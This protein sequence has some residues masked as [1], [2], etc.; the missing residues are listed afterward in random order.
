M[1]TVGF[2]DITPKNSY[3]IS[4]TIV[5]IYCA[6]G[7]FAYTINSI[8]LILQQI[9]NKERELKRN[10]NTLNGYMRR[11]KIHLKLRTKIRN[12]LEYVWHEDQVD[13]EEAA[14]EI[15]K[16][17]SRSLR[18]ELLLNANGVLLKNFKIFHRNFSEESLRKMV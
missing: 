15:M 14:N 6:C 2:G 18:E 9:N 8:G 13:N 1:N 16:K 3:E 5:F 7:L 10:M 12:F 17:L 4:F 11:K